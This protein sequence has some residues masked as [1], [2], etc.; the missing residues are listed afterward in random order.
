MHIKIILS[1]CGVPITTANCVVCVKGW[2]VC[3]CVCACVSV[4]VG[5]TRVGVLLRCLCMCI[6]IVSVGQVTL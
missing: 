4:S 1:A 2:V 5:C 6:D 3:V